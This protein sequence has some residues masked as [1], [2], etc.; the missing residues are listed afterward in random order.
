MTRWTRRLG[1]LALLAAGLAPVAGNIEKA[2]ESWRR[3]EH[4]AVGDL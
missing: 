3:I 4:R 2:D 1:A